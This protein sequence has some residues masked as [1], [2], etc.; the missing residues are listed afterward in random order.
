MGHKIYATARRRLIEIW[1][2]TDRNWGVEQADHYIEGLFEE[3]DLIAK[4][5][6]RWKPVQQLGFKGVFF[7]KYRHHFI[8][9]RDIDGQLGVITVL[10][11][12]MD[13]PN[14][15]LDDSEG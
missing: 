5:P 2:Y 12:S 3:L 1:E 6:H 4:R 13:I 15:L 7:A 11:E 10:H 8:F 9:F 14:R